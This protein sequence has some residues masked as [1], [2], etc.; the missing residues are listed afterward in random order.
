MEDN[1]ENSHLTVSRRDAL[2][3]GVTGSAATILGISPTSGQEN[4]RRL[5][6]YEAEDQIYAS[7]T[8]VNETVY[9]G[10]FDNNFYALDASNG[11]EK[12]VFETDGKIR[13]SCAMVVGKTAYIGSA[14]NNLYAISAE[15]G[16]QKWKF[17]TDG[18]IWSSPTVVDNVVFVGSDDGNLYAINADT[19]EEIWIYRN[20]GVNKIRSSPAVA[21]TNV[22][23]IGDDG[24]ETKSGVMVFFVDESNDTHIIDAET[25]EYFTSVARPG[26]IGSGD[27]ALWPCSPLVVDNNVFTAMGDSELYV[28]Q[29]YLEESFSYEFG[30]LDNRGTTNSVT[31][32]NETVLFS[33]TGTMYALQ[34]GELLRKWT[35]EDTD[36]GS[37]SPTVVGNT[38]F[39]GGYNDLHA[40]NMET[41]DVQWKS[42]IVGQGSDPILPTNS[43]PTVVDGVVY[44]AGSGENSSIFAIDAD[45]E[46][47]SEDMRVQLGVLGH[48]NQYDAGRHTIE[49]ETQ[50]ETQD[51]KQNETTSWW[52]WLL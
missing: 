1:E 48:N 40:V 50:D 15:T 21:D 36:L 4:N 34:Q 33:F 37:S 32:H 46:D 13:T 8:V 31:V 39:V 2:R 52:D 44:I 26:D 49:V 25:G 7:P 35:Y 47:S 6:E 38:A 19:G 41:G 43:S 24:D 10:S 11:E 5:W 42:S 12:W 16:E 14:D 22:T 23:Q 29:N 9:I 30:P 27:A 51:E 20:K 28:R 45:V 18:E 3:W 17:E